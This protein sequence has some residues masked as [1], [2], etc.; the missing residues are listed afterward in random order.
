MIN[1]F[2]SF[3]FSNYRIG[4]NPDVNLFDINE[5]SRRSQPNLSENSF[6]TFNESVSAHGS[7]AS[8]V[9]KSALLSRSMKDDIVMI[10]YEVC[11][12][13]SFLY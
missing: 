5:S 8:T 1:R 6:S 10:W 3:A 4:S 9:A 12:F 2:W 7:F 11:I 13:V